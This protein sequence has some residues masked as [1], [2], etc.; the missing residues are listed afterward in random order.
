[1]L[2]IY[3]ILLGSKLSLI[4]LKTNLNYISSLIELILLLC[5]KLIGHICVGLLLVSL[6]CFYWSTFHASTNA[7][8]C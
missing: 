2:M 6:F 3:I 8:L 5:P 7:R 1:M 4:D